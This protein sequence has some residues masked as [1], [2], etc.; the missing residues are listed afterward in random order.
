MTFAYEG[1]RRTIKIRD[2]GD[3]GW[4]SVGEVVHGMYKSLG[5]MPRTCK[6]SDTPVIT[7]LRGSRQ[8]NEKLKTTFGYAGVE[9]GVVLLCPLQGQFAHWACLVLSVT[10]VTRQSHLYQAIHRLQDVLI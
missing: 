8:G 3:W 4:R 7:V 10:I 9:M 1:D 2:R 5:L 6:A